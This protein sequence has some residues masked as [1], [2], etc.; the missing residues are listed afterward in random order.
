MDNYFDTF[1]KKDCNGCKICSLKCPKKA[2]NMVEDEEGFLYPVID[3]DKCINCNSC[4]R[5]CGN[6]ID[7][8]LY[9]IK[10]YA[11]KNKSLNIR[12]TSTSGGAFRLFAN[13]IIE[14]GGVVYGATNVNNEVF[15]C[16]AKTKEE[17]L[18]FSLSKYVRSD[19]KNTFDEIKELVNKQYVLFSGTPCQCNALKRYIGNNF[20]NLFTCEIICHSNPSKKIYEMVLKNIE[21]IE[22]KKVKKF[23]FR[24]K[25]DLF[26]GKPYCEFDDGS[27]KPYIEYNRAFNEMLISRPSCSK[28]KFS[29]TNRKSDITMGDFWG[30]DKVLP[31]FNDNKGVSLITINSSKG[32]KIFNSI[33][34]FIDFEE[35][36]VNDSF[37][38]NHNINSK[39]NSNR[40]KFFNKIKTNEIN[41]NNIIEYLNKYSKISFIK[42]VINK[43]KKI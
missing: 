5:Y 42:K 18:Q 20:D 43:L 13:Y 4:K 2:I 35:V 14:N 27:L 32:E 1:N 40:S 15:H 36:D 23:L 29:D 21:K 37:K 12:E 17:L 10:S 31:G 6:I 34:E 30:I 26:E 19:L 11:V 9:D 22:H 3:K 28:C 25:T 24:N 16:K 8:N 7:K 41:E 38:Y 39:E 33:K